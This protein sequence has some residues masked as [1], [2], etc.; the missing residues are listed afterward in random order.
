M[1]NSESAVAPLTR[2]E[3]YDSV[4]ARRLNG[5]R[6]AVI[7]LSHYPNDARVRR[8]A[9]TLIEEGMI[10]ELICVKR[11]K[12]ERTRDRFNS[13][14]ILR[15][16]LRH[17]RGGKVA[18][19]FHYLTFLVVS[20]VLVALRSLTRRYDL[21][22]VHNMPDILVFSALVPRLLG[23]KLVIDLHDP[24]PELMQSIFGMDEASR[25]V[26]LLK[27]LERL[28]ISL[29][30]AVITVN[31]TCRNI[32]SSRSCAPEKICVVMNS[33]DEKVFAFRPVSVANSMARTRPFV[34]MYHGTLVE[35][36]G[37][38]LA[39]EAVNRVR[40]TVPNVELRVYG[41]RT[42]YL[43][44]VLSA[45]KEQG[46]QHWVRYM[47]PKMLDQIVQA[48]DDCDVGVV[49]NLR[50]IFTQINT[51]TRIFEFLARGK[52][53]IAPSSP[54]VLEYFAED[55]LVSFE[56]GDAADLACKIELVICHPVQVN[57]ITRRGQQVCLAHR[58]SRERE[59]L[60]ELV[61][62]LLVGNNVFG[63]TEPK[64][65]DSNDRK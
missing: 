11:N 1:K 47:G 65:S 33:P 20:F 45:V 21:V 31:K 22:H 56:L 16:P 46:N 42:P 29:A 48:I 43:E 30:D 15:V 57:E 37:L 60:V 19:L 41:D 53:V 61:L 25:G 10:V 26:R 7:V 62:K 17:R 63:V 23:A 13:V 4:K 9:E 18:Y 58:W 40:Q 34:V 6:A 32:F 27:A 55:S 54:G 28:S 49:P 8:A 59:G 3:L 24:M 39:V 35:R 52:P 12:G 64:H 38:G 51:P 14:E 44:K 2:D 36:N 5:K 50:S